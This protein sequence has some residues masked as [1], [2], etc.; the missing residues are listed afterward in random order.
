MIK[1]QIPQSPPLK[2][3]VPKQEEKKGGKIQK[4]KVEIFE[5]EQETR[6]EIMKRLQKEKDEKKVSDSLT[7]LSKVLP[8]PIPKDET[9]IQ[10][11]DPKL[12][13]GYSLGLSG[14]HPYLNVFRGKV[15]TNGKNIQVVLLDLLKSYQ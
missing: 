12:D 14:N 13:G 1:R 4:T 15:K 2:K 3:S 7:E 9:I 6:S 5:E 8:Q 11:K 10:K